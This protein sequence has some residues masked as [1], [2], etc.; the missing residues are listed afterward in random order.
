MNS[1]D[2]LRHLDTISLLHL[3]NSLGDTISRVSHTDEPMIITKN[4]KPIAAL[5]SI[6]DAVLVEEAKDNYYNALV[7]EAANEEADMMPFEDFI[8][9]VEADETE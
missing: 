6:D 9:D 5:V 3:R 4:G 2:A 8:A 1:Q 7:D